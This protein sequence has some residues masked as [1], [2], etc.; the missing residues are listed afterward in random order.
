MRKL[1]LACLVCYQSGGGKV[2]D[3]E[4]SVPGPAL[5][6]ARPVP[7][8]SCSPEGLFPLWPAVPA[9]WAME[10]PKAS[11]PLR[12]PSVAKEP[13]RLEKGIQSNNLL[14]MLSSAAMLL[15]LLAEGTEG[16]QATTWLTQ[17][18]SASICMTDGD[19]AWKKVLLLK[20]SNMF[21]HSK[22]KR[23]HMI[24]LNVIYS[25][26][27]NGQHVN[28]GKKYISHLLGFEYWWIT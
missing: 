24:E 27:K 25:V 10:R 23:Q 20:K 3:E 22:K 15:G 9:G 28:L 2:L 18:D 21:N 6:L 7:Q 14:P 4:G 12:G 5:H 17:S 13:L 11:R 16:V 1:K 26:V 8:S 19:F